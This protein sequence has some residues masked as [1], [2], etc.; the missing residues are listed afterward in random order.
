MTETG[1]SVSRRAPLVVAAVTVVAT[2]A[3]L[4]LSR[5]Q[6]GPTTSFVPAM[7]AIVACFDLMSVYLLV[8]DYRDNGEMRMLAMS[9]AYLWSL[10]MMGGYA[11]AFP[12]VM[13]HPP[14][15]TAPSVAP[16]LYLG[17]HVGFPVLLGLAWSVW[18]SPVRTRTP[19]ESRGRMLRVTVTATV[20]FAA[21][22]VALVATFGRNLPVV[23]HGLD[24]SRMTALTAPV[25]LPLVVVALIASWRGV[26]KRTGP[27]R[28][29]SIAILVCLCDLVLTYSSHYR[30]SLGWYTGRILTGV[31]SG[32]VLMAMLASFR[33]LKAAAELQAS[34]DPL[35][36]AANRRTLDAVLEVE[37]SRARRGKTSV[38]VLSLDLDGF[39]AINDQQGHAAGDQILLDCVRAWTPQLRAG[40]VLA[41]TG[42]DEFV[43]LLIDADDA[44]AHTVATRL[45]T[46]TPPA[47]GVSIGRATATGGHDSE[48]LLARADQSMYDAKRRR[49]PIPHQRPSCDS[50]PAPQQQLPARS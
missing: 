6:L 34:T 13:P 29:T 14:L 19:I 18:P 28:W 12:G 44:R 26:R 43:V 33:R 25:G 41:R 4:P 24:T 2:M 35:T 48:S 46:V 22:V 40:D 17:W 50:D 36:G 30:Y 37:L 11:L 20:G 49:R 23:I 32:V 27:E 3:L 7:L 5:H 8:G 42:G 21:V 47:V 38:A 1:S 31:G 45:A 15:A 9:W 10:V 39:K 16:W